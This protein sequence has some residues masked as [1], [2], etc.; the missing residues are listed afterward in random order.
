MKENRSKGKYC[1]IF[2]VPAVVQWIKNLSAATQVTAGV[3]VQSPA[4]RSELKE[5]AA[6]AQI[7]SHPGTSICHRCRKKKYGMG[8]SLRGAVV[9]ETD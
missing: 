3:W 7:Q 1:V 9:N 4:W 5:I 8:S 2:G 6:V